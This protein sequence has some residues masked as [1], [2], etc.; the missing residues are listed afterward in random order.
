MWSRGA[1]PPALLRQAGRAQAVS[2]PVSGGAPGDDNDNVNHKN[3]NN[4]DDDND[5]HQAST[6]A[7]FQQCLPNIG[8]VVLCYEEG[9]IS[10]PP[11]VK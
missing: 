7:S 4:N 11:P 6:G 2:A 1:R 10:L 3:K 8:Q 9:T 5:V